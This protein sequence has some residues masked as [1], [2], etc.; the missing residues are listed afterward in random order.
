MG[1]LLAIGLLSHLQKSRAAFCPSGIAEI[2]HTNVTWWVGAGQP[3]D[4][5]GHSQRPT[6]WSG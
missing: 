6:R 3:P 1:W 2:R 4:R 5:V